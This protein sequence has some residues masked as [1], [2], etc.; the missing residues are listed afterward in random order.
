MAAASVVPAMILLA[1]SAVWIVPRLGSSDTTAGTA[2][3]AAEDQSAAATG[4][5]ARATLVP[6]GFR[7]TSDGAVDG[8]AGSTAVYQE[9][10]VR[11][12]V[13]DRDRASITV[14]TIE[15]AFDP[16]HEFHAY[17]S[18]RWVA[19]G[20]IEATIGYTVPGDPGEG[21]IV[22]RWG[23]TDNRNVMVIG[24]GPIG[25]QSL[26]EVADTVVAQ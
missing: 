20:D 12:D 4:P 5:V 8:P 21:L 10:F 17:P 15:G 14:L 3:P 25:E 18:A 9:K 1:A 16:Q 6:G 24:R 7:R 19:V 2:I 23:L 13:G 26:L 22:I 11:G